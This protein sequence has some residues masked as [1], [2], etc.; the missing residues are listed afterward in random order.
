MNEDD[1]RKVAMILRRKISWK[2][3]NALEY[4]LYNLAFQSTLTSLQ[5]SQRETLDA[6][7]P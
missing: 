1:K 4:E 3:R 5:S 2:P 7:R 6:A